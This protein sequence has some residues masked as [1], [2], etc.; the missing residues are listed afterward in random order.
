M[1]PSKEYTRV[2][3]ESRRTSGAGRRRHRARRRTR[4]TGR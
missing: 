1:W 2:T 3:I 4:P